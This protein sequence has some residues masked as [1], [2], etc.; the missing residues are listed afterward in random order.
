LR[1]AL[2]AAATLQG[3]RP[4]TSSPLEKRGCRGCAGPGTGRER[5]VD[6]EI[7]VAAF[8]D[9]SLAIPDRPPH[10][11]EIDTFGPSRSRS[12][13]TDA[14][15]TCRDAGYRCFVESVLSGLSSRCWRRRDR[16]LLAMDAAES[17]RSSQAEEAACCCCCCC[18]CLERRRQHEQPTGTAKGQCGGQRHSQ[19][20]QQQQVEIYQ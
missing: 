7:T 8:V 3:G 2:G 12:V 19:E 9:S 5:V 1:V 15:Q 13:G 14:P 18:C 16:W 10:A 4:G 20:K 11:Q 6:E 17:P